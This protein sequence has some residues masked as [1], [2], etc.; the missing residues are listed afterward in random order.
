MY[1]LLMSIINLGGMVSDFLGGILIMLLGL[2]DKNFENLTL[3]IVITSL[4]W[5]L[6]LLLI[7][8]TDFDKSK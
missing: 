1:A 5:S 4:S 8:S 2:S 6:P 3:L 7:F